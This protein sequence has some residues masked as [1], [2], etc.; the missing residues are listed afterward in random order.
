[1][2]SCHTGSILILLAT[3]QGRE[4]Q[5][6]SS[7]MPQ[8]DSAPSRL[9]SPPAS[10]PSLMLPSETALQKKNLRRLVRGFGYHLASG[11]AGSGVLIETYCEQ[12]WGLGHARWG[13]CRDWK[14]GG[15][16]VRILKKWSQGRDSFCLFKTQ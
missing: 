10:W 13:R 2:V 7:E 4:G 1:M 9:S 6:S 12:S 14:Q 15:G 16:T 8:P 11:L 5:E 3:D